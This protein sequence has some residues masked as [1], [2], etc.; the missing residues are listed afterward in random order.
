MVC[1]EWRQAGD[2]DEDDIPEYVRQCDLHESHAMYA[3]TCTCSSDLY[4][5]Q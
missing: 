4:K 3:M 1:E 2:I 5:K